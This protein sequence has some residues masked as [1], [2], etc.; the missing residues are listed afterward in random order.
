MDYG[1][2]IS[3]AFKVVRQNRA[4]WFLGFLAALGGIGGN[5]SFNLPSGNS[6]SLPSSPSSSSGTPTTPRLPSGSG[7]PSLPSNF[8]GLTA[9]TLIA[10]GL[11]ILCFFIVVGLLFW[12]MG[13][14]A[15]GG[16]IAGANQAEEESRTS[17]GY[18]WSR[19]SNKLASFIG[20]RIVLAIPGLLIGLVMI[21]VIVGA[22]ASAGGL[23]LLSN[24]NN[25]D[26]SSGDGLSALL[27]VLS[28]V[29]CVIVP[30][31]L[32]GAVWGILVNGIKM[33]GDR[34]IMLDNAHAMDAIRQGWRLF[35]GNFAN[36]LVMGLLLWIISLV[37]GFVVL[38]VAGLILAPSLVLL[39]M[40][41]TA[42]NA[43]GVGAGSIAGVIALLIGSIFLAVVVGSIINALVVAFR[44]TLWTLAYR[45]FTGR[46][47]GGAASL[48]PDSPFIS[49][50]R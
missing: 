49:E 29:V 8:D 6:F 27:V 18:A 13:L 36:V 33:L 24:F 40:Q 11:G 37:I 10:I 38:F 20:M 43:N 35:R 48:L 32:L 7:L 2:I 12:L 4:L 1:A 14:V 30:L 15:N 16:L 23:A 46:G 5:T 50:L 39:V 42:S 17:F 22:I 28:G 26:G 41:T 9:S 47:L 19:G 31:A 25:G 21:V 34:A 44:A 3:R 45:Q